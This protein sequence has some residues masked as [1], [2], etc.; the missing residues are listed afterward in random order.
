MKNVVARL[1]P[2][3]R[4]AARF[5]ITGGLSTLVNYG[6]FFS[7]Y[8]FA[9]SHYTV[10]YI[11]GYLAGVVVGFLL[12]KRWTFESRHT[13]VRTEIPRYLAL[14]IVTLLIGTGVL[15]LLVEIGGIDPRIS[16]IL[17]LGLTTVLNFIGAS[18]FVF[19]K[20]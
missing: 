14:Y 7:L 9:H 8:T 15:S 11:A 5:A 20:K 4:P 12:N 2:H 17:V 16:N 6:L 1:R 18:L 10:A 13:S 19:K 3:I